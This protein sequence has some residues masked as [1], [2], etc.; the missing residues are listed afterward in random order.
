MK[1]RKKTLSLVMVILL[2]SQLELQVVAFSDTS[3]DDTTQE[4]SAEESVETDPSDDPEG[5][6]LDSSDEEQY[7][8]EIEDENIDDTKSL[9][10]TIQDTESNLPEQ[11][12][13]L[14]AETDDTDENIIASS[15]GPLAESYYITGNPGIGPCNSIVSYLNSSGYNSLLFY[16]RTAYQVRSTMQND[17]VF[18]IWG[19]AAAGKVHCYSSTYLTAR[20]NYDRDD[21][22]SLESAFAGTTNK[23]K[24]IRFA[25]FA[26]CKTGNTDATGESIGNLLTY[27]TGTLGA[28]CA[29][30]F[31]DN[32]LIKAQ[33]YYGEKLFE[34]LKEGDTVLTATSK[35][36]SYTLQQYGAYGGHDSHLYSGNGNTTLVPAA[37]GNS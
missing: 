28:K 26:G 9:D 15:T 20:I 12:D 11:T 2:F 16:D 35:A 13:S 33:S 4:I 19:H 18:T 3:N 5:D 1:L 29:L 14:E 32:I 8:F 36:A 27:T 17:A 21:Y 31:G 7:I 23:L 30:G 25:Y 37:F 6:I 22:Y 24:K 10:N 34:R